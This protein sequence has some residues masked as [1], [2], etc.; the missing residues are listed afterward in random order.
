MASQGAAKAAEALDA[1]H[2]PTQ[3]PTSGALESLLVYG[4][5]D[6]EA[7]MISAPVAPSAQAPEQV[8][9]ALAGPCSCGSALLGPPRCTCTLRC[10]LGRV[11]RE[12]SAPGYIA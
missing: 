5:E 9:P 12:R 8:A 10:A 4:D 1:V 6:N 2:G 11:V 3:Q 7:T